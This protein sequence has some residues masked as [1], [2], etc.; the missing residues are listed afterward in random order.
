M[1]DNAYYILTSVVQLVG[2]CGG[3]NYHFIHPTADVNS[4]VSS[5]TRSAFEYQVRKQVKSEDSFIIKEIIHRAGH[6]GYFLEFLS[7][8]E[9]AHFFKTITLA[10]FCAIPI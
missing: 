6:L 9:N 2:E 1:N 4:V 8:I 3:K 10:H 7:I 5:T